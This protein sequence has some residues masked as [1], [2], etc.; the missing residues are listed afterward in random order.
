MACSGTAYLTYKTLSEKYE[1][2]RPIN[3]SEDTVDP[4]GEGKVP[5]LGSYEHGND[6]RLHKRRVSLD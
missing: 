2:K 4:S 5:V 3:K 6:F 1:G